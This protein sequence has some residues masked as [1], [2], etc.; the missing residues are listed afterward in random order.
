MAAWA[1]WSLPISTKPN[2]LERPVSRSMI[3]CADCTAPWAPNICWRSLSPTP[4]AKLPTYN[5]LPMK[6]LL[7]N[8]R[9][10][11]RPTAGRHDPAKHEH[12]FYVGQGRGDGKMASE[13][14]RPWPDSR[15]PGT[16]ILLQIDAERQGDTG[17]ASPRG[18]ARGRICPRRP[19]VV[20]TRLEK[21]NAMASDEIDQPVFFRDAA[22]P[23][24]R[25]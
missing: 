16:T 5:F 14:S 24:A 12:L 9:P 6:G 3:T 15:D 11:P 7:K 10:V 4:N 25:Q 22:R 13:A 19:S 20:I 21:V 8:C 2:P 17:A 18:S 23:G 1:S